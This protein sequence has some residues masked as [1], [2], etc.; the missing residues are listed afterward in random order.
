[1]LAA[2]LRDHSQSLV[3]SFNLGLISLLSSQIGVTEVPECLEAEMAS[4][5]SFERIISNETKLS[6]VLKATLHNSDTL[7]QVLEP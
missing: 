5:E 3:K 7:T 6:T 2:L 4:P 1:M